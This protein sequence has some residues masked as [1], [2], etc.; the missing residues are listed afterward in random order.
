MASK[1]GFIKKLRGFTMVEMMITVAILAILLGLAVPS[2]SDF[3]KSTRLTTQANALSMDLQI[4]RS[5]AARRNRNVVVCSS[6]TG[7]TCD[8]TSDWNKRRRSIGFFEGATYNL[9]RGTDGPPEVLVNGGSGGPISYASTG[10]LTTTPIPVF[11]FCNR[12]GPYGITITFENTG[13]I[14]TSTGQSCP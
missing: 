9:I 4:A 5:E 12:S 13:R 8:A 7:S 1:N 6:D 2:F 10:L 11:T 14:K 3:I